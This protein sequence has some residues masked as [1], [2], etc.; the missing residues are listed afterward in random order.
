MVHCWFPLYMPKMHNP[1]GERV[2]GWQL[3]MFYC[4]GL[5]TPQHA[6]SRWQS[7]ASRRA[8]TKARRGRCQAIASALH[9]VFFQSGGMHSRF[10]SGSLIHAV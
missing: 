4:Q 9:V 7:A 5:R 3:H 6:P 1:V 10:N 2:T 8:H